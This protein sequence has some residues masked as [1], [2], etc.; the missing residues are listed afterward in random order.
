MDRKILLSSFVVLAFAAVGAIRAASS[1]DGL[2][3]VSGKKYLNTER[4]P[5]ALKRVFDYSAFDGE[6]LKIRSFKRM[7]DDAQVVAKDGAVGIGLGHFVTKGDDGRGV[8]AC[9]FYGKVVMKFEGEGIMEFGEK[10]VMVVEAPCS[11][12]ADLNRIDPIWIPFARLVSENQAPPRFLEAS[13]PEQRGVHFK[14]E[15]MT[16]EWPRQWTL[17]SVRLFNAAAPGREV[18][19]DRSGIDTM[20]QKP[21][22]ITF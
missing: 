8:L 19:I 15:N 10:P 7:I 13:F 3:F 4:Y 11:V 5:A 9:D 6:P 22:V 18:A 17:I 2:I 12:S 1:F 21:L 20:I 16:T 14:F